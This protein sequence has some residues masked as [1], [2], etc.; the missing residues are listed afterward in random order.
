MLL[1][2]RHDSGLR[3][4]MA[5][6]LE[7]ID[8]ADAALIALLDDLQ[9]PVDR[10]AIRILLREAVLNAVTHG[11]GSNPAKTVECRV[12]AGPSGLSLDVWDDGPGF[13]WRG[14]PRE[15]DITGDGGRGLPL[16]RTYAT[17]MTY[18]DKGNHLH[19]LRAYRDAALSVP[20]GARQ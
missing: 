8:E 4:R 17:E 19:L 16:M 1:L 6:S 5:A 10:F 7:S 15:L 11:S 12:E 14:A 2:E 18:N 9:A 3:M 20:V 13:D